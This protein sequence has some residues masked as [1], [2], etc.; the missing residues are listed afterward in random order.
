MN[1]W[2]SYSFVV[3]TSLSPSQPS[4]LSLLVERLYTAL[5]CRHLGH[6][7]YHLS[8]ISHLTLLC[9]LYA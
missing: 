5:D 2:Y 6:G 1:R 4:L 9:S 8:L 7:Q 3:A